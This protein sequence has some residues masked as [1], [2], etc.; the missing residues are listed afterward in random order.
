MLYF[1]SY[2][3]VHKFGEAFAVPSATGKETC[4]IIE[5]EIFL[6]Y[7]V[8][9]ELFSDRGTHFKCKEL[10]NLCAKYNVKQIFTTSYN[11]A[12]NGLCERYNATLSDLLNSCVSQDGVEW[13]QKLRQVV[14]VYNSTFQSST[15]VS[16]YELLFGFNGVLPVN[17]RLNHAFPDVELHTFVGH[18][19]KSLLKMRENVKE[20]LEKQ[21]KKMEQAFLY[22]YNVGDL[23]LVKNFARSKEDRSTKF[24]QRYNGPYIVGVSDNKASPLLLHLDGT[25][26]DNVNVKHLK[27]YVKNDFEVDRAN[28]NPIANTDSGD[29][30]DEEFIPPENHQNNVQTH[31]NDAIITENNDTMIVDPNPIVVS[32]SRSKEPVRR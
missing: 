25:V 4:K 9:D 3:S 6:R 17:K 31:N 20:K 24:Q 14:N 13:C 1:V 19:Q 8:P 32:E 11:P 16:P 22:N 26:F 10:E 21:A 28:T 27:K 23:V 29:V 5:N 12:S 7:G 30:F 15:T 18:R 2:R